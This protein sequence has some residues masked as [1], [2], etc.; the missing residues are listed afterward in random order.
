MLILIAWFLDP[1]TSLAPLID[2][3]F[4]L[5][6]NIWCR[7][8]ILYFT[9][10]KS[11][12][13]CID[14][15]DNQARILSTLFLKENRERKRE[16]ER[17]LWRIARGN[18]GLN[19]CSFQQLYIMLVCPLRMLSVTLLRRSTEKNY[20]PRNATRFATRG[21]KYN[22]ISFSKFLLELMLAINNKI[23]FVI[24]CHRCILIKF[25]GDLFRDINGFERIISF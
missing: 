13:Y 6:Q 9:W 3:R 4:T 19:S 2:S 16:E 25:L 22:L 14:G 8:K 7:K 15:S 17:D 18:D 12:L 23:K 11:A 10:K 21:A 24:C 1:S 5:T 20:V